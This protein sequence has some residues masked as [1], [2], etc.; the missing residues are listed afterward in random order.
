MMEVLA[1]LQP[2]Y[3]GKRFLFKHV[4]AFTSFEKSPLADGR[5]LLEPWA[6]S[7]FDPFSF[8]TQVENPLAPRVMQA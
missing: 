1:S 2:G 3:H 4:P 8:S 6:R 5:M 7:G